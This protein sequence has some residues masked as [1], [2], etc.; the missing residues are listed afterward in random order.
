M[1]DLIGRQNRRFCTGIAYK[2]RSYDYRFQSSDGA[3]YQIRD[4]IGRYNRRFYCPPKKFLFYYV[5]VAFTCI[6]VF[7]NPCVCIII[8]MLSS[9]DNITSINT[10]IIVNT[11]I[12]ILIITIDV[13]YL[14]KVIIS[15][16]LTAL[17]DPACL[18]PI[19]VQLSNLSSHLCRLHHRLHY[20][21]PQ[22]LLLQPHRHQK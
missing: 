8:A 9:I 6:C 22:P 12:S 19:P 7:F 1:R 21:R 20:Q 18:L 10:V 5:T 13:V 11:K 14:R 4:L 3:N 15:F 17:G 16:T 2:N